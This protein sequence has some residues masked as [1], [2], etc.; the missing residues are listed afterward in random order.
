MD[1]GQMTDAEKVYAKAIGDALKARKEKIG[2]TFDDL[3]AMSGVS[4]AN[5]SRIFYGTVDV[6]MGDLR[7]LAEALD[8]PVDKILDAATKATAKK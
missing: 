1:K 6:R 2:L 3:A 8:T 5:V 4:R 7:R